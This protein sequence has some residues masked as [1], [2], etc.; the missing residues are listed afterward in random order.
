MWF[1]NIFIY[2]LPAEFPAVA[3]TA[4]FTPATVKSCL[5]WA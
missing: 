2:R 4:W 1:K 5:R 3:M